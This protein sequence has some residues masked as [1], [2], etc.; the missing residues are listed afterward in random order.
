M[1]ASMRVY[2]VPRSPQIRMDPIMPAETPNKAKASV[3]SPSI[4]ESSPKE[5][6]RPAPAPNTRMG[7]QSRM[8]N[9]MSRRAAPRRG[10]KPM[11]LENM[12]L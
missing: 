12:S 5:A 6:A 4:M 11:R 8:V 9:R 3:C 2:T 1:K 7:V 10:P